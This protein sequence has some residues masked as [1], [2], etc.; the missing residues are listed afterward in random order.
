MAACVSTL[1][2]ASR[3]CASGDH[4]EQAELA[5]L[6]PAKSAKVQARALNGNTVNEVS[7][8]MLL[9]S[10]K[11]KH[12][13]GGIVVL[14]FSPGITVVGGYFPRT[15]E[16]LTSVRRGFL[17]LTVKRLTL[18]KGLLPSLARAMDRL[19]G[20]DIRQHVSAQ[21]RKIVPTDV[22]RDE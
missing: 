12:P 19:T 14:D 15:R 22:R 8:T 1:M 20:T 18:T 3:P 9:N 21:Y 11:L 7:Q 4:V 17:R 16:C 10:I 6:S 13:A 5:G 2:G